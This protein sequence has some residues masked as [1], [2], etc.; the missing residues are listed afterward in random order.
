METELS[1][2]FLRVVERAAIASART[3]GLGDRHGSDQYFREQIAGP[4]VVHVFDLLCGV[5][6]P[7]NIDVDTCKWSQEIAQGGIVLI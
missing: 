2:E 6:F 5:G 3:M 4:W 7:A 1:L